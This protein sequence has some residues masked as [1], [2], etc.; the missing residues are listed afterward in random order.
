MAIIFVLNCATVSLVTSD[1]IR[2]DITSIKRGYN[3]DRNYIKKLKDRRVGK[4]GFYYIIDSNGT[5][6]F[7][8]QAALVGSNFN[9]HWFVN[10]ILTDKSG[11][12]TYQLGNRTHV[13]FFESL[14]D[15]E[16][17]CLSLVADELQQLPGECKQPSDK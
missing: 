13:V 6:I 10:Q 12:I 7:H 9:N 17:L 2:S 1:R 5:V 8:P 16:I 4:T 14:G 15:S 3:A 11:C